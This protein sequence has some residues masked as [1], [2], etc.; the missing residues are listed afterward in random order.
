MADVSGAYV[1]DGWA[2]LL[3][4]ARV[5]P[6][7]LVAPAMAGLP[8]TR[9]AQVALAVAV[10]A[11]VASGLDGGVVEAAGWGERV[12]VLGREAMI[13]AVLGLVAAVPLA[14]AAAAGAW[15]S[16]AADEEDG[17]TWSLF[18][19]LAAAAVFFAVGGH[20]AVI[21]ALGVS[22]RALPVGVAPEGGVEVVVLAGAQMVAAGLAL[23]APLLVTALIAAIVVGVVERAAGGSSSLVPELAVRRVAVAL[24]GAAAVFAIGLAVTGHARALPAA[25]AA[26]ITRL[27]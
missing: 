9:V 25:L 24:A 17:G 11:V 12:V 26:A 27:G 1:I 14:G 2:L 4:V 20:L 22:Y 16:A 13:G 6:V 7:V 15:A 8:L 21:A 3:A 23:A 10:A 5:A 18:F 19:P